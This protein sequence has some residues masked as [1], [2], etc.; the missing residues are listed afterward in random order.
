MAV[1]D[2]RPWP[3]TRLLQEAG[4]PICLEP[5]KAFI[6]L[7]LRRAWNK[8]EQELGGAGALRHLVTRKSIS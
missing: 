2:L 8:Q 3:H 1:I 7:E 5:E 6:E 4:A